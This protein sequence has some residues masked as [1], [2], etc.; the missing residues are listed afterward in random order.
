MSK[1]IAGLFAGALTCVCVHGAMAA[2]S[3]F[4]KPLK[5]AH[6]ALPRDK[7][8]PQ[9]KPEVRCST[10]AKFM[11]KEIDLGEE[12]AEQLS[13]LPA[14]EDRPCRKENAPDEKIVSEHDWSGYFKGATG[15]YIFFDADDGWNGGLGFAVF[16]PDA[17][18]IFDDVA[19]NG[20]SVGSVQENG[21]VLR[22]VRVYGAKCSL[23]DANAAA[24]WMTVRAQTGIDA[25][26]PD[27]A[28]L[29]AKEQKRTPNMAKQV[30]GDP[31]AIEYDVATT[32]TSKGAHVV[33]V[34]GRA[35]V[36]MPQE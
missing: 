26:M 33:A 5:V 4:D 11:V 3:G 30:L 12:G 6:A 14:K 24:C 23:G 17:K 10:F 18:K 9:A 13:I 28:K 8:N 27:C 35:P 16:T 31:A 21:L 29:Y 2:D 32:L 15:D 19:K 25:P 1:T 36:C 22:Y 7:D 20:M 34:P